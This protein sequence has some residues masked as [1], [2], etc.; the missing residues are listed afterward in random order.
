M[1]RQVGRHARIYIADFEPAEGWLHKLV[2]GID[3]MTKRTPD[4]HQM[5]IRTSKEYMNIR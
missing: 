4:E 1:F 5:K 3:Q 2:T